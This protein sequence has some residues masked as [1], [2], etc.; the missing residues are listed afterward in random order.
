MSVVPFPLTGKVG[1][2]E[3]MLNGPRP[4]ARLAELTMGEQRVLYVLVAWKPM[5]RRRIACV[6]RIERGI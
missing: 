4:K 1:A 6:A 2:A 3:R 5:T